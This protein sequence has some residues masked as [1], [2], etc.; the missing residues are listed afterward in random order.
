MTGVKKKKKYGGDVRNAFCIWTMDCNA[1]CIQ[2][3][4]GLTAVPFAIRQSMGSKEYPKMRKCVH[5][6]EDICRKNGVDSNVLNT[7]EGRCQ[8]FR[9]RKDE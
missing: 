1:F 2:K 5:Y 4:M 8:V 3:N 7:P 6:G 9:L